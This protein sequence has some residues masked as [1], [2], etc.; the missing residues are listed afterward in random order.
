MTHAIR[1]RRAATLCTMAL[2]IS[3]GLGCGG[4]GGETSAAL[5]GPAGGVPDPE[6]NWTTWRDTLRSGDTLWDILARHQVATRDVNLILTSMDA[7]E[8]FSWRRI[9]PGQILEGS[10]DESGALRRI[11]YQ[12]SRGEL[13]LVEIEGD[14]LTA[15][16]CPVARD[17]AWRRLS[18]VVETSVDAALRQVGGNSQLLLQVAQILSWD[19]DFFTDPRQGDTLDLVVEEIY[20]DGEF[21][22]YG[23]VQ[24][25]RYAGKKAR[26]AGYRFHAADRPE[27]EYYDETGR[28]LR[29]AFLKSP[30]NYTRIS[31]R[32]SHSR[33][34]PILK[35]R[36]P[37]L[38]VDYAAPRGTPIVSVADG[39][40]VQ[41]NWNGGFG[42]YVKIRHNS[43]TT[44]TYGHLHRFAKGIRAGA[45]VRQNQVIG[46]VGS[47]GLSTG[48]HLDY[49]VLQNG[50]YIDPLRM[51]NPPTH[52][53]PATDRARFGA[54]RDRLTALAAGMAPGERGPV[55][56]LPDLALVPGGPAGTDSVRWASRGSAAGA[57]SR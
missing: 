8:P 18:A 27:P 28:N 19:V 38:G 32:F 16:P 33:L 55:Q 34:H 42:R 1:T 57:A 7:G 26:T 47:T 41:A 53:I 24:S 40:V 17:Y 25:V 56:D 29:K 6:P 51:K 10:M 44:T 48:P 13:F 45:R 23:D 15:A 39:E 9:K 2:L 54:H 11:L 4:G 14:S 52:P 43:T 3:L 31:S 35:K 36:R 5:E 21:F 22:K 20:I 37:H 12:R 46:Y 49:R 30:L 50:Q